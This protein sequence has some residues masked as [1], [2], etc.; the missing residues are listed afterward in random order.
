MVERKTVISV[1]GEAEKEVTLDFEHLLVFL[2]GSRYLPAVGTITEKLNFKHQNIKEEERVTV[3][4]CAY[5]LLFPVTQRYTGEHFTE[6]I[7]DDI[8]DSPRFGKV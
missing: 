2:T 5:G 7:V 4:T 3:S 8:L 6:N 1:Q